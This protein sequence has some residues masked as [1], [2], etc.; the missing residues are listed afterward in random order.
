MITFPEEPLPQLDSYDAGLL[1][2]VIKQI[3]ES[4]ENLGD[5]HT[6]GTAM[7]GFATEDHKHMREV[8]L[9]KL[10]ELQEQ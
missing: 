8:T 3:Y 4:W 9:K 5:P 6:I 7:H 2:T 1:Y 10:E